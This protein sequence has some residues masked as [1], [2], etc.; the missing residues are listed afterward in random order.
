MPYIAPQARKEIAEGRWPQTPGELNYVISTELWKWCKNRNYIVDL[1]TIITD[2]C[3]PKL[4]SYTL[5]NE[6]MGVL[7]CVYREFIRRDITKDHRFHV[8]TRIHIL[9]TMLYTKVVGPYEDTKKTI[10]GDVFE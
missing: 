9:Q 10:N 1:E 3:R 7:E 8:A 6:V 5:Y 4:P 2:Y